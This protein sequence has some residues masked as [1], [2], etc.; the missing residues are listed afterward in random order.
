V[1]EPSSVRSLCESLA[2]LG[3]PG[4]RAAEW[5]TAAFEAVEGTSPRAGNIVAYCGREALMALLDLGG[6]PSRD[7]TDAAN[8]VIKAA[9]AVRREEIDPG[10]LLDAVDR[11]EATIT[12][13]GPHVRRLVTVIADQSHRTPARTEADLFHAYVEVLGSLNRLTHAPDSADL[14]NARQ[15]LHE[16]FV[17]VQRLFAPIS[18]RLDAIDGLVVVSDPVEDDVAALL[19]WHG[20]P[21]I[22]S[23][24]F[25][26]VHGLSWFRALADHPLLQPPDAPFWPAFPYLARLAETD[27]EDVRAWLENRAPGHDLSDQQAYSLIQ[28][29]LRL[30][31]AVGEAVLH[32]ADGHFGNRNIVEQVTR[33]LTDAPTAEHATSA[34]R[35]IL[36]RALQALAADPDSSGSAHTATVLLQVAISGATQD[37]PERWLQMLCAKTKGM[38]DRDEPLRAWAIQR[39]QAVP[40]LALDGTTAVLEQFVAAIRDVTQ[41]AAKAGVPAGV[42]LDAL[43]RLPPPLAGRLIA[44][45]LLASEDVDV[46]RGVL[47]LEAEVAESKPMPET[48]SLLRHLRER[49]APGLVEALARSLGP[50]PAPAVTAAVEDGDEFP[51]EWTRTFG[52]SDALPLELQRQWADAVAR[53]VAQ[54]GAPSPDG[55]VFPPPIATFLPARSPFSTDELAELTPLSAAA[56]VAS[57]RP[58]PGDYPGP[59]TYGL[60]TVVKDL[61][62]GNPDGWM[63]EDA[64]ELVRTLREPTYVAAYFEAVD[65]SPDAELPPAVLGAIEQLVEPGGVT[66]HLTGGPDITWP[67]DLAL[68]LIPRLDISQPDTQ[69][70]VWALLHGA[71]HVNDGH[72]LP[73]APETPNGAQSVVYGTYTRTL[74]AAFGVADKVMLGDDAPPPELLSLLD[75]AIALTRP[76]GLHART[77]LGSNL[78]WLM[79]NATAWTEARWNVLIGQDAPDGLGTYTFESYLQHGRPYQ[80]LLAAHPDLYRAALQSVPDAARIHILH[81]MLWGIDGYEPPTVVDQLRAAGGGAISEAANW[82]ALGASRAPEVDM[83]PV[84]AFWR[85]GIERNLEAAEYEGFGAFAIV[86]HLPDATWLDLTLQTAKLCAGRL[87]FPDRIGSRAAAITDDARAMWLVAALLSSNLELWHIYDLG[88]SGLEILSGAHAHDA[89]AENELRE[90]LL[91]RE[92]YDART[93]HA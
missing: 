57:W 49:K 15:L 25:S 59:S 80:A 6:P 93:A 32:I 36:K 4:E 72:N 81:G 22:L 83:A 39:I 14:D 47:L 78:P 64:A 30:H 69:H 66:Q 44:T 55:A 29:A 52:W 76:Q 1:Q 18:E 10:T 56:T 92:F 34:S 54:W 91:E 46:G 3:A 43:R 70:R 68:R 63:G 31:A 89:A 51:E 42:R 53:V 88:R 38:L 48:L 28:I 86:D 85:A 12:G 87:A 65:A 90:R 5:F 60:G 16:A 73:A 84:V 27:P 77:A 33:Y 23:Y 50:P 71:A 58:D 67:L 13:P 75:E 11:L 45:D 7:F 17:T 24:F 82:L 35:E 19:A 40:S 8:A 62:A 20:D 21:R 74:G 79:H 41:I 37:Q 26:R 9:G 61:I 2:A